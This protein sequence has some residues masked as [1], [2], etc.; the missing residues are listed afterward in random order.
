M[1]TLE[2]T[3][4]TIDIVAQQILKSATTK[5][6]LLN[7]PMGVGKTTLIKEL[8]IKLGVEDGISSPTYSLVNEYHGSNCKVYHFDLYRLASEAEII[9]SGL[10]DYLYEDAFIFIEWPEKIKPF[11][12]ENYHE[13][14]IKLK[15]NGDRALTLC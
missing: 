1:L 2:Y 10:D 13:I 11:L 6:F 14:T 5:L 8:C 15:N 12:P 4:A 9:S 7:A 3:L